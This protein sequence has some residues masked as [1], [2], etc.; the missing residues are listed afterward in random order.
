MMTQR[1]RRYLS[2]CFLTRIAAPRR[3]SSSTSTPPTTRCTAIKRGGSSTDTMI[4]SAIY[5]FMCSADATCSLPSCA[6]PTSTHLPVRSGSVHAVIMDTGLDSLLASETDASSGV[7][8][9]AERF[10]AETL[11][12]VLELP[13]VGRQFVVAPPRQWNVDPAYAR[14][15]LLGSGQVGWIR[16]VTVHG[17][18][19]IP[20]RPTP[21]RAG[22]TYTSGDRATRPGSRHKLAVGPGSAGLLAQTGALAGS[23]QIRDKPSQTLPRGQ[24]ELEMPGLPS[25]PAQ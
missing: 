1:S 22:L 11:M 23:A 25:E 16:P 19:A 15:V 18:A 14:S 4:A 7:A 21:R 17:V 13:N 3:R 10:F 20:P 9:A 6:A 5:R 2:S 12:M 8:A 24:A